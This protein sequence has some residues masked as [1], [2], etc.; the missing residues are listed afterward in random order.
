VVCA[1]GSV[2]WNCIDSLQKH[3][4]RLQTYHAT[5]ENTKIDTHRFDVAKELDSRIIADKMDPMVALQASMKEGSEMYFDRGTMAMNKQQFVQAEAEL[6]QALAIIP[7]EATK[8]KS[9]H[10]GEII[11]DKRIYLASAYEMRACCCM[12]T[13]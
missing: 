1:I 9:W 11:V 3:T 13:G 12:E 7:V 8:R 4:S 6:S 5:A 2:A 10:M